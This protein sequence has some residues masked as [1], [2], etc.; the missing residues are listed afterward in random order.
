MIPS[1]LADQLQQGVEDFLKTTFPISTP[2]FHG[3]VERLIEREEGIFKGPY[4]DLQLPFRM[5]AAK[6][7][8]F[9]DITLTFPPYLHQERAFERLAGPR[10]RST[11]VATG[12]GSGKTECFLYPILDHCYRM[13]AEPGIKAILIY[14]MNAL[15]ADQAGR[16]A[17]MVYRDE[18]LKG[19]VTAGLF[20]GQSEKDPRMGMTSDAIISHKDTLRHSPPDILLTNY[21]ML[22][23]LLIRAGDLP[24][25]QHNGPETL[26]YLLVDELHTFDGAQGTDLA[27]LL[28]RL[29]ARLATP[30]NYLCCVGTSATLGEKT[31]QQR[32]V[33]YAAEIF[34]EAIDGDG[35]ITEYRVSAG[36]FLEQS[37]ISRLDVV[38]LE[39]AQRLDPEHYNDF[40]DYIAAQHALWFGEAVSADAIN[41]GPWR[42]ALC[43]RLKSHLFF[44]NLLKVLGGAFAAT[45]IFCPS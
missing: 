8:H 43:E 36:E 16:I 38:P 15:A 17:G 7:N 26:R 25:W 30:E 10:P 13:R 20:V 44:Q 6:K 28:R 39:A 41:D 45:A 2:F 35:I 18:N 9:P 22:D 33:D 37:L 21:K 14:P 12:T 5:G 1:V 40:G 32:L 27:C 3:I 42:T 34:G 23:Y 4:L 24:L 31:E 11:I 19:N 29:K